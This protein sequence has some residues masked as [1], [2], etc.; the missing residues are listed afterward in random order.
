MGGITNAFTKPAFG[1]AETNRTAVVDI[2]SP[3]APVFFLTPFFLF[4]FFF[5][6]KDTSP[7][8]SD[9]SERGEMHERQIDER[10]LFI[11]ACVSPG[12]LI[13]DS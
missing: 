8:P 12:C 5:I 2:K 6:A 9:E 13:A 1:Y 4:F 3:P 11:S 10:P 7:L